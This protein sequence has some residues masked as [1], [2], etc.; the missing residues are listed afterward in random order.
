MQ[1]FELSQT[2][3]VKEITTDQFLQEY[4]AT[5]TP[6]VMESITKDWPA[7]EKWSL[8]YFEALGGDVNVNIYDSQ[9][10]TNYKLQHAAETGAGDAPK[11]R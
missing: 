1:M 6:V 8:E 4:K 3:R 10:S 7:K 9:P 11:L 5:G 2:S